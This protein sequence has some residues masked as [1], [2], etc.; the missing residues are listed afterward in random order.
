MV[1]LTAEAG[2]EGYGMAVFTR[3][4]GLSVEDAKK[5][6]DDAVHD[7]RNKNYHVYSLL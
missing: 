3:F 2:A 5:V 7:I 1:I 4:L 6:C